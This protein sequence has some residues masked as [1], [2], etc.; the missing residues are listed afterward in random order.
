[1]IN[2]KYLAKLCVDSY[3]GGEDFGLFN[4]TWDYKD[5]ALICAIRGSDDRVD[6]LY[7]ASL[8]AVPSE[9]PGFVGQCHVGYMDLSIDVAKSIRM[10]LESRYG[11]ASRFILTGHSLGGALAAMCSLRIRDVPLEV[12]TFGSPK[13][14]D[15][16]GV[17]NYKVPAT[18]YINGFDPV[19][20]I[21]SHFSYCKNRIWLNK[22][23]D[24]IRFVRNHSVLGL[25]NILD[26]NIERYYEAL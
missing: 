7:N 11:S 1:M 24:V 18:H 15:K 21:P 6:W 19:P 25:A 14:F 8:I 17:N 23:N 2:H 5:D 22:P 12:I 3:Y 4:C 26:H 9:I 13:I 20:H 10:S 16:V